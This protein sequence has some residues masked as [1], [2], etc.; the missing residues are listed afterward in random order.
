MIKAEEHFSAILHDNK[1]IILYITIIVN[2]K[3]TIY[4]KIE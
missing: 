3:I 4:N 1:F 2:I